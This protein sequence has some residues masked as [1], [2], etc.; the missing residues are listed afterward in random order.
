MSETNKALIR[1]WFEEVWNQG[2]EKTI[3]EL[4]SPE[5][6]AHG[7]GDTEIDVC[8]PEQF[9]PFVRNL[10]GSLP[11]LHISVEDVIAENDL[12]VARL[13]L[14]ATHSGPGLGVTPSGRQVRVAGIAVVR[15]AN[16]QAV[17]AW[18]VWDQ[19][20]LLR[21]IGALPGPEGLDRFVTAPS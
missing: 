10:R 13:V 16:G 15:F 12:V 7:L 1:R 3:D 8:G 18:N 14:Q 17:E 21:Q 4:F 9:K 20:G 5:G 11:D 2:I 6:I 19:L